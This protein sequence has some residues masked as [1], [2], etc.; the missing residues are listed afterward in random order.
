MSFEARYP[1]ECSECG[2]PFD[3]GDDIEYNW[4]DEIVKSECCGEDPK[5]DFEPPH[6]YWEA[7]DY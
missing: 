1:G 6:G 7:G 2:E 3:E 5:F 4:A